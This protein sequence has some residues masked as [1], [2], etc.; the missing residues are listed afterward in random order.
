MGDREEPTAGAPAEKMG[1]TDEAAEIVDTT[2]T[3]VESGNV[4]SA[5]RPDGG[6]VDPA[7]RVAALERE[8][9]E[10]RE[11][12]LRERAEV[13]NF[14]RRMQREKSEALRFALEP[15]LRDLLPVVDNLE[16]A[17][18]HGESAS[19]LDGIKMVHKGL[20]DALERSG[21]ARLDTVG[22]PFDPSLHE[23]IS[24]AESAEFA[25]GAVIAQHQPGYKLHDRLVR[26][27]LVTV[28]ARKA[29]APVESGENSD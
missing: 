22:T 24:Q 1:R 10:R 16:R 11:D 27:A 14:K 3:A 23:A 21:V 28:N 8:L 7:E 17:L 26:P 19:L 13:E 29:D 5:D 2:A 4:A 20:L 12:L 25:P 15:L 9:H 6:E 18:E